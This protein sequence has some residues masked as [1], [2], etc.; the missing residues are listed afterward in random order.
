MQRSQPH[1]ESTTITGVYPCPITGAP[2]SATF[3][4]EPISRCG[5][6]DHS[7]LR[8]RAGLSAIPACSLERCSKATIPRHG[9]VCFADYK[10]KGSAVNGK[11]SRWAIPS[12]KSAGEIPAGDPLVFMISLVP[13]SCPYHQGWKSN[14]EHFIKIYQRQT[15]IFC[16]KPKILTK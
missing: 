15:K 7:P 4:G 5:S 16:N 1:F 8:S 13:G 3:G 10:Q 6:E 11:I 12:P 2:V 14:L 9:L